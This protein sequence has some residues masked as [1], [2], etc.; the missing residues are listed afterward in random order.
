M[1][2]RFDY[3]KLCLPSKSVDI[4]DLEAFSKNF[5][6]D[7]RLTHLK[8][9]KKTPFCYEVIV[10]LSRNETYVSFTGKALLD[11]YPDLISRD[12]IE[13]CF[14]HINMDNICHIQPSAISEAIVMESDITADIEYDGSIKNL[15]DSLILN[16]NYT[17]TK[18]GINRFYIQ[19]TYVTHRKRECLVVYDKAKELSLKSNSIFLDTVTNKNDQIKYFSNKIRFELNLRSKDRL[20]KYFNN[21]LP[22]LKSLLN[23]DIDPISIFL[24]Q[25]IGN[26]NIIEDYLEECPMRLREVEHLLLLTLFGFDL[27]NLEKFVK[28]LTSNGSSI[29]NRMKPYRDIYERLTATGINP[30]Y[31]TTLIKLQDQ[32]MSKFKNVFR[33][34][35]IKQKYN[36]RSLYESSREKLYKTID[37]LQYLY[38]I[39]NVKSPIVP[40]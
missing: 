9:K 40:D 2:P 6:G 35:L 11:D 15:I 25:A 32:F 1:T 19:N 24:E 26:K 34:S 28:K 20:Q 3:F 22:T 31:D 16:N 30:Y 5:S 37:T 13:L 18:K 23:S 33:P 10:D 12:N 38:D 21:N 4:V 7:E 8:Y 39:P 36:L 14:N 27:K 17:I 29:F